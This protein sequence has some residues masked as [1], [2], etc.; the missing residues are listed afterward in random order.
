VKTRVGKDRLAKQD[1]LTRALGV[2]VVA[3]VL[4]MAGPHVGA[5]DVPNG[6]AAALPHWGAD[7]AALPH[8]GFNRAAALPDYGL[9][10]AV[11]SSEGR[12]SITVWLERYQSDEV[13]AML[14]L[15]VDVLLPQGVSYVAQTA[16][17]LLLPSAGSD[18]RSCAYVEK[19]R[20][21]KFFFAAMG[22]DRRPLDRQNAALFEFCVQVEDEVPD[23]AYTLP[24]T[25]FE[26][27][28]ENSETLQLAQGLAP[29]RIPPELP[30]T[31]HALGDVNRDGSI[32]VDDILLIRG[33]IFGHHTLQGLEFAAADANADETLD[34]D[35]ILLVRAHIFGLITLGEFMHI[36]P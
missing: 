14:A 4:L 19:E 24:I 1:W 5:V 21:V 3:A 27:V 36:G 26:V 10:H 11:V 25:R 16:Q 35:D 31:R 22:S 6:S 13:P 18:L 30:P 12:F 29:V 7:A 17:S 8:Y 34:I 9:N 33:H 28:T 23:I 2:A 32:D 15:Q 20:T